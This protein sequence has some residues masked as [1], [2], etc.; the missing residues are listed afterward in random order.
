MRANKSNGITKLFHTN[1]KFFDKELH[2]YDKMPAMLFVK[3]AGLMNLIEDYN[4]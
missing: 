3:S 1:E 2:K 4:Q